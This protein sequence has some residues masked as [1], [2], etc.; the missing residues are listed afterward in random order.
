MTIPKE[1]KV[2]TA[3]M[4]LNNN[5]SSISPKKVSI[6]KASAKSSDDIRIISTTVTKIHPTAAKK[7]TAVGAGSLMTN[8]EVKY[9]N[10][11]EDKK[12]F[13]TTKEEIKTASSIQTVLPII[14]PLPVNALPY[15]TNHLLDLD[16][17][18][19]ITKKKSSNWRFGVYASTL[20]PQLG[21]FR[22]GLFTDVKVNKKW[23][24]HLGLGY[25]KR[26]PNSNTN[27]DESLMGPS[28]DALEAEDMNNTTAG[29]STTTSGATT[30]NTMDLMT[31][32]DFNLSLIHI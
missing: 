21:S 10:S 11:I 31:N 18:P 17:M 24:I 15:N 16:L 1:G 14:A 30:T 19:P 23:S 29:T 8:S 13:L 5:H 32:S 26:I 4:P 6:K 9:S 12:I 27:K 25:A 2:A 28:A 3:K 20:A 7:A 22:T